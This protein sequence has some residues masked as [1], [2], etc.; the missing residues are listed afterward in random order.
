VHKVN[1]IRKAKLEEVEE[2]MELIS[3]C[4][5]VMQA[6][7]SDQWDEHYPNKEIIELDIEQGTLFVCEENDA[8]AGILVL[9]E[10]P[11]ETYKTIRWSQNQGPHL[12]MHRLAVHPHI[13]GKGIAT[14][15]IAFA[16]DYAERNGYTSI[17]MD[18]YAKNTRALEIYPR[19]GY[20]HRGEVT[21]PG[22]TANFPVFEKVLR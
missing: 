20:I 14:R 13:Q 2:I 4:V 22:R 8:I 3:K 15:L 12:I 17:R 11:S 16:E 7:G 6:A 19:L 1:G 9:D 5:Q 21:Y 10:N 18:T